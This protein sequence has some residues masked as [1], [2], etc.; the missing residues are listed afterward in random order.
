MQVALSPRYAACGWTRSAAVKFLDGF[1]FHP[2]ICCLLRAE[3]AASEGLSFHLRLSLGCRGGVQRWSPKASLPSA[4][5]LV[6]VSAHANLSHVK[7][8][9][10]CGALD[11]L[12][13]EAQRC[14]LAAFPQRRYRNG[15]RSV[16]PPRTRGITKVPWRPLAAS[17]EEASLKWSLRQSCEIEIDLRR[18][19]AAGSFFFLQHHLNKSTYC[20]KFSIGCVSFED[21]FHWS[22]G[23]LRRTF[24]VSQLLLKEQ[25]GHVMFHMRNVRTRE[26]LKR[27][28]T[29]IWI[30]LACARG[31]HRRSLITSRL[32]NTQEMTMQDMV[33]NLTESS[34]SPHPRSYCKTDGRGPL[35]RFFAFFALPHD[36]KQRK[37][38]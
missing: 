11:L 33:A 16:L 37:V 13:L 8:C 23:R 30:G 29:S 5:S 35:A 20:V 4:H 32:T 22:V 6:C 21:R 34:I 15:Q 12:L 3:C 27:S 24:S 17:L 38:K 10:C 26:G 2:R 18:L 7:W 9:D 25:K 36:A 19:A 28:N 31:W 1:A 14:R